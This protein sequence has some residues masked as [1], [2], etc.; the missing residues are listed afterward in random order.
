MKT[1]KEKHWSDMTGEDKQMTSHV[2]SPI[3]QI[4]AV[5]FAD[6]E[7]A[8]PPFSRIVTQELWEVGVFV[9]QLRRPW[10]GPASY[11]SPGGREEG[12]GEGGR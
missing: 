2:H 12:R 8:L 4:Y 1:E 10:T 7:R 9:L 6:R 11:L 5:S 3:S